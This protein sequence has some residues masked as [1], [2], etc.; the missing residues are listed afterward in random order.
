MADEPDCSV[1]LSSYNQP[2]CLRLV[3]EGFARQDCAGFE[4]MI[5]DFVRVHR[6]HYAAMSYCV[7]GYVRLTLDES[8]AFTGHL[9]HCL[10]PR[11]CQGEV[12]RTK[13]DRSFSIVNRA[14]AQTPF[15][16][17][18]RDFEGLDSAGLISSG[19]ILR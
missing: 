5:A 15:G 4:V 3:L 13:Q 8:R 7:G 18:K 19:M 1:I 2:N 14:L 12:V 16:L 11:R 9:N 6:A 10:D 17:A